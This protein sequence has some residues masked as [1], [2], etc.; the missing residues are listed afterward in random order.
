MSQHN[1]Q[2]NISESLLNATIAY[3][4]RRITSVQYKFICDAGFREITKGTISLDSGYLEKLTEITWE[5]STGK[6]N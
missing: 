5:R 3:N 1:K 6:N 4:E 2:S